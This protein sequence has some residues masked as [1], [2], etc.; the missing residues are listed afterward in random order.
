MAAKRA[1]GKSSG[2]WEQKTKKTTT[3][4]GLHKSLGIPANKKIGT[5]R[6]VKAARSRNPL[7][8]KQA[9]LAENYLGIKKKK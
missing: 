5:A 7:E 4:G 1:S 2:K 8:K 6:I 9:I 3:A